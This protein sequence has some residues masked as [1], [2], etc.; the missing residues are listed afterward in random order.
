[1][2]ERNQG[3]LYSALLLNSFRTL[4]NA[5]L[6]GKQTRFPPVAHNKHLD[7]LPIY[8]HLF[9]KRE[10]RNNCRALPTSGCP[11]PAA[12]EYQMGIQLTI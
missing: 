11:P 3:A 8:T 5:K 4:S 12:A 2:I 10:F 6:F 1:M 9:C 7:L